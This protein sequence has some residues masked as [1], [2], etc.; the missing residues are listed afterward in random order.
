MHWAKQNQIPMAVVDAYE[1]LYR[2][3]LVHLASPSPASVNLNQSRLPTPP[4]SLSPEVGYQLKNEPVSPI[5]VAND[6]FDDY[7]ETSQVPQAADRCISIP[8]GE[9]KEQEQGSTASREKLRS[10][11]LQAPGNDERQTSVGVV[12]ADDEHT[13]VIPSHI[14]PFT[15]STAP[16]PQDIPLAAREAHANESLLRCEVNS[17]VTAATA[18]PWIPTPLTE[19]ERRRKRQLEAIAPSP[20]PNKVPRLSHSPEPKRPTVTEIRSELED[21]EIP[22]MFTDVVGYNVK[23]R[24]PSKTSNKELGFSI[25]VGGNGLFKSAMVCLSSPILPR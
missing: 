20:V 5:L 24:S 14:P 25:D 15:R 2:D 17:A 12:Q 7:R 13:N 4:Q 11:K 19:L 1:E 16:S 22:S 6:P 23:G 21:G 8:L 18:A 9:F 10:I 3:S